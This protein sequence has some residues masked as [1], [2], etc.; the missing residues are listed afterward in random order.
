MARSPE[1]TFRWMTSVTF[2][3]RPDS[4]L[5]ELASFLLKGKI[6]RAL[7][8]DHR[9]LVGLVTTLDLVRAIADLPG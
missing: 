1:M 4:T 6:H 7:V 5:P 8:F 3:V 2:S 9:H